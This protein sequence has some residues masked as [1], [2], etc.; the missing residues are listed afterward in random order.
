MREEE[1]G[2]I[3][4]ADILRNYPN[5][6][7]ILERHGISCAGC[8]A[9]LLDSLREAARVYG[10]DIDSLLKDLEWFI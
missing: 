8:E 5:A 6:R 4:I 10:V 2:D 9:F 1:A 3:S 7:T